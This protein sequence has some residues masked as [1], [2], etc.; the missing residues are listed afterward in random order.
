MLNQQTNDWKAS[1]WIDFVTNVVLTLSGQDLT[2]SG[3]TEN[4][5]ISGL[6]MQ[7]LLSEDSFDIGEPCTVKIMLCGEESNLFIDDL[8]GEIVSCDEQGV[9]VMFKERL[10]WY[11]LF[12]VFKKKVDRVM[13]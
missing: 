6:F 11:A 7:P 4:L 12:H 13:A 3:H 9:G 10:E 2:V 8:A 5:S 1:N